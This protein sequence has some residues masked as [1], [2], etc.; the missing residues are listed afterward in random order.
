[1]NITRVSLL[2]RTLIHDNKSQKR[3][4]AIQPGALY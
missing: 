2:P 3:L 1:M 4:A